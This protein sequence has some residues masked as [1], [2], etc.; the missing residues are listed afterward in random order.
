MKEAQNLMVSVITAFYNEE[1]F[2]SETIESV[3]K[4]KYTNWELILVDDGS[5]DESTAIAKRYADKSKGKIIYT[6]HEGH[7]NKGVCAS[8]N[9]AIR[10]AKG[11]LLAFLDADDVWLPIK[12]QTQVDIM[13]RNPQVS[14]TCEASLSWYSW[15]DKYHKD[16]KIYVGNE[17]DKVF[18]P[19]VLL[20]LL[21]PLSNSTAPCPSAIMMRR[22][23]AVKHGG[24]EENFTGIYQLYEDQV[25]LLKIYL[26]EPVF[27][28]SQCN[29]KYRQRRGSC[30]QAVNSGGHYDAVRRFFLDW[31]K[32][33]ISA[34]NL[35]NEKAITLINKAF[36]KLSHKTRPL[37]SVITPFRNEERFIRETIESVIN[38]TYDTWEFLLIDD[39]STDT[40][41]AIVKEYA[42]RYPNKIKYL[43]HG[44][45]VNRGVCVTRNLGIEK[46][47]GDYIAFLDGDDYWL[48]KKLEMQVDLIKEFPQA[49]MFCEATHYLNKGRNPKIENVDVQVGVPSEKMYQPPSLVFKLY[50]LGPGD[51][52]CM[53]SILI[54]TAMVR[55]IGGFEESFVGSNS[56][57][58]DQAFLFKVYFHSTVYVSSL[59]NNIYRQRPDSSMH[60]LLG[61]GNYK[62]G[63]KYFLRWLKTYLQ[64]Q[65]VQYPAVNALFKKSSLS[66]NYPRIYKL[67]LGNYFKLRDALIKKKA[68]V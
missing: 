8:R 23:T 18:D 52:P 21:Y 37:V 3:I 12:L 44:N 2:L 10:L 40:S 60:K 27:I 15:E 63:R 43:H 31:L 33:Y 65:D 34:Q 14:M 29:N 26:N 61:A 56:L 57:F 22:E 62:A 58:E 66:H 48:P 41:P 6:E 5:S 54:D 50:P 4:Q 24:F 13:I 47:N 59:C 11:S 1:R 19:P 51:A 38:Q 28:S 42:E 20:E 46:A 53:N 32:N 17:Q 30:V 39:G 67:T 16:I 25:F 64:K 9:H 35:K 36:D 55:A 49:D 7:A 68:E 45:Y